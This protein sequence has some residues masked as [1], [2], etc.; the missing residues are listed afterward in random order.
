MSISNTVSLS[1][2]LNVTPYYDDF[3][4]SKNFHRIL[5]RPGL[6]VQ[7]RE[8]TQMQ[9]IMQN[10]IDRFAEHVFK[11]G[12]PVRGLQYIYENDLQY[13]KINDNDTAGADANTAAFVGT[14]ITGSTSGLTALVTDFKL[15][16]EA[17]VPNTK[18][19]YVKYLRGLA[20]N[21]TQFLSGETL[22]SNASISLS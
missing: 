11:E 17:A 8:L 19:L 22:T 2:D 4:E 6:A 7:A 1:T 15:G 12:T 14:K 21:T 13:V 20:N 9:S 3:D 16:S 5:Y 10:Q 18:T